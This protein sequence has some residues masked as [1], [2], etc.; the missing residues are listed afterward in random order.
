[1]L[2]A[3]RSYDSI[4]IGTDAVSN[5]LHNSE[6]TAIGYASLRGGGFKNVAVGGQALFNIQSAS[7][8]SRFL[9]VASKE[10]VAV[11]YKSLYVNNNGSGNVGIGAEAIMNSASGSYNIGIGYGALKYYDNGDAF[12]GSNAIAIG[13]SAT[14]SASSQ[15]KLGN[16]QQSTVTYGGIQN[17]ADQ[18]DIADA[19]DTVLGLDFINELR[20]VDFKWNYR[21]DY[22]DFT[23]PGV[24]KKRNKV[25][26]GLIAQEVKQAATDIGAVF[27]GHI[28]MSVSGNVDIQMLTYQE[29]IPPIIKAIQEVDTRLVTA[30]GN[31]STVAILT[32]SVASLSA[33]YAELISQ[34]NVV[35]ETYTFSSS[36]TDYFVS[37]SPGSPDPTMTLVKGRR[38]RFDVGLVND[39]QPIAFRES[40]QVTNE[41]IGMTNNSATSGRSASSQ[42]TYIFYSVPSSPPYSSIIYQ[43]A[44]TPAMG[45]V[46]NLVDP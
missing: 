38:Y 21:E 13:A 20:P 8:E 23:S 29:F 5:A 36:G 34:D 9:P 3:N 17:V 43:S 18:R 41:I 7:V 10:N 16:S 30:E 25:H 40:D 37:A 32:A 24:D 42:S 39:S 4:V 6:N 14:V 31:L 45:G 44:N 1:L 35:Y 27:G 26:H 46:I 2:S 15:I 12:L 19:T 33:A 22:E 28:D 11:G